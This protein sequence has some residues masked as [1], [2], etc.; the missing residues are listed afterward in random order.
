M[1]KLMSI[2]LWLVLGLCA[3]FVIAGYGSC[4]RTQ[5]P[6]TIVN[7]R[8]LLQGC[9]SQSGAIKLPGDAVVIQCEHDTGRDGTRMVADLDLSPTA[10]EQLRAAILQ[11]QDSK[12]PGI[13]FHAEDGARWRRMNP[14][15]PQWWLGAD[16]PQAEVYRLTGQRGHSALFVMSPANQRVLVDAF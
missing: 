13:T 14:R 2:L 4:S 3:G 7:E 11:L 1:L 10:F 12:P 9:L 16:M 15:A 8:R 5:T 6:A